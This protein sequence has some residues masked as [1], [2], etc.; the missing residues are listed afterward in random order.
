MPTEPRGSKPETDLQ[1]LELEDFTAGIYDYTHV[2][3][4]NPNV[5]CPPGA[6]DPDQTWSCIALPKGGLGPLPAMSGT[7]DWPGDYI[8]GPDNFIVGLLVHNELSDGTYEAVA[9]F[10]ADDGTDQYWQAYSIG[11]FGGSNNLITENIIPTPGPGLFGSPY[12]AL[13]RVALTDPTTTVGNPEVVFPGPDTVP[14][15]NVYLYPDPADLTAF[16]AAKLYSTENPGIAGQVLVHQSRILVLAGVD[17]PWPAG[18]GINVNEQIAFTDPP[19]SNE[20]GAAD[21]VLA[22]EQPYGYGCGGSISAGELFLVKKRGGA[23]VV[24]GDIFSPNVTILP[25]VQPTGGIYGS[26]HSGSPGFVYCSFDNGAWIWNGGST[27]QKISTQLDDSF[28]LPPSS[29]PWH[30]TTTGSMCGASRTGSTSRI[31]G[32][33]TSTRA[34]GGATTRPRPRAAKTCSTC[35]RPM[36]SSFSAADFRSLTPTGPSCTSSTSRRRRRSGSGR[37]SRAGSRRT[38]TSRPGPSSCGRARTR[39]TRTA[40]SPWRSS[41]ASPRSHRSPPPKAPSG[42]DRP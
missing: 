14:G 20:L 4:T 22:T 34:R 1:W 32:C 25:G 8:T 6:A 3:G 38:A 26:A 42:P 31:T 9:I 41:M 15:G 23:I 39:A 16:G 17:Y 2:A 7:T 12:P 37:V 35:R 27:A 11:L 30:R 18:G 13:T 5:P 28:F 24:T 21:T 33:T 10:Q 36:A 40:R 19:N 29:R